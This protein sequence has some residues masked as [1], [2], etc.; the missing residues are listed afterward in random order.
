MAGNGLSS[1]YVTFV[2]ICLT[3]KIEYCILD[4]VSN[5]PQVPGN[6]KNETK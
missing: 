6:A 5:L 2:T 3:L 4:I 1:K